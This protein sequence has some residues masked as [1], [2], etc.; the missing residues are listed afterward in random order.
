MSMLYN[1]I[2]FVLILTILKNTLFWVY[3]WQL[4]EY[5]RDRFIVH[6]KDTVGGRNLVFSTFSL[7]KHLVI[8]SY[9]FVLLNFNLSLVYQ[10]VVFSIFL[11]QFILI[12][13]SVIKHEVKRPVFSIKAILIVAISIIVSITL[14]LIPL[15]DKFLWALIIDKFIFIIVSFFV[16]MFLFPSNIYKD[17]QAERAASKIRKHKKL[18]VIGVTGSYG[19]TSTKDYIAQVLEKKFN[20]LKTQGSKNTLI[21]ITN[22]ILHGL[23]N[24]T[25]I[26]V[27]EMGAYRKGE[28]SELCQVVN[29]RIGV[30]TGINS[31]HE[32]LFGSI[33]KTMDTKYELIESLPDKKSLAIFN[34]NNGYVYQLYRETNNAKILYQ[35]MVSRDDLLVQDEKQLIYAKNIKIKKHSLEFDAVVNGIDVNYKTSLIGRHNV[36]NIL[37][38]IYLGNYLGMNTV[39]IQKG[40]L[41]LK[42]VSKSM[43]VS[44]LSNGVTYIDDSF[45]ANPDAVLAAVDYIKLYKGRRIFVLQPLIEL[46]KDEKNEHLRMAKEIC[47]NCDVLFL[48]NDNYYNTI[49]KARDMA[50]K[51]CVVRVGR[52]KEIANYIEIKTSIND[53]V[54][55]EGKEAGNSLSMLI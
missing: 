18:L 8:I 32:A 38:A 36:E 5:R 29:P 3:L 41:S 6:L 26:F 48:T 49:I 33:R 46:G 40:V 50:N 14:F 42:S 4:K 35:T 47:T 28:I 24:R 43:F 21:G 54:V 44:K 55:F 2:T 20:V 13:K 27:C 25:E 45:N 1:F 15:V 19:K 9:V 7:L 12:I 16:F 53:I 34:G 52:P 31:Q 11:V 17:F 10:L 23:N 51:K 22:A 39:E 30:L 37:P